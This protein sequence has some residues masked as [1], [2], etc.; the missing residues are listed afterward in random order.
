MSCSSAVSFLHFFFSCCTERC[1]SSLSACTSAS[2]RI[3][4]HTHALLEIPRSVILHAFILLCYSRFLAFLSRCLLLCCSLSSLSSNSC[5]SFFLVKSISR[6]ARLYF[7]C[8]SPNEEKA[9][10]SVQSNVTVK[11]LFWFIRRYC[12]KGPVIMHRLY[13]PFNLS[14]NFLINFD[15]I[16]EKNIH[17][18]LQSSLWVFSSNLQSPRAKNSEHSTISVRKGHD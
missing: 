11:Y 6:M 7:I 17:R 13:T 4:N 10:T 18:K 8:H 16:S 3:H 14:G 2:C 1:I 12:T 5:W 9:K 15:N